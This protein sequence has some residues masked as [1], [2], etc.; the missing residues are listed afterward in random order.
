[1][2]TQLSVLRL[3]ATSPES[4]QDMIEYALLVGMLALLVMGTI[5]AV[6]QS[7]GGVFG[8]W[9]WIATQMAGL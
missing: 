3:L 6:G 5:A 4:G 7:I 1:M 9:T 8:L 2:S